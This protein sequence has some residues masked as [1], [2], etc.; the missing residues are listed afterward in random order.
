TRDIL[1]GNAWD[2]ERME[3]ALESAFESRDVP[4]IPRHNR[5]VHQVLHQGEPRKPE[6][7][8]ERL[9][10]ELRE[11]DETRELLEKTVRGHALVNG[12]E[13]IYGFSN[14]PEPLWDLDSEVVNQ[15][16]DLEELEDP[17]S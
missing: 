7:E 13:R 1:Y 6:E 11:V 4:N 8:A 12:Y 5:E 17:D 2:L 14:P 9:F 15:R 16:F 10:Q 3:T